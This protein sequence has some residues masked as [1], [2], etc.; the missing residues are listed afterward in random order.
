ME[1]LW[2][3]ALGMHTKMSAFI[4]LTIGT[5]G[6]S[7]KEFR[8][9]GLYITALT[10]PHGFHILSTSA[11]GGKRGAGL[12]LR[13]LR[14]VGVLGTGMWAMGRRAFSNLRWRPGQKLRSRSVWQLALEAPREV[15]QVVL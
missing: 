8:L 15:H 10:L 12:D 5:V 1:A 9:W 14:A 3:E 2:R 4:Q 11:N 7:R 6:Q 13:A